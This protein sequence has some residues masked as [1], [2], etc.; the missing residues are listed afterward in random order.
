MDVESKIDLIKQVGEEILT[1]EELKTLLETKQNIVAY[2]GF[3]PSGT[4]MHI[5]QG[6]LRAINVNKMTEAG[7]KFKM[8]VADWHAW[9]NNKMEGDL[10][11]IQTVGEYMIEVWKAC[12][13]NL[14]KVEFVHASELVKEDDYWKKVLQISRNTTIK[15]IIRTGQIMG[16]IESEVQHSSQILYPCMQAADIFQ[17]EADVCQLGMDQRKV[18]ILARELGEKLGYWK[19]IVV[20]HH[21]L[22]G[23]GT[24][25]SDVSDATERAI[26]LKMSKSKPNTA[27]FMND[28]DET[29]K[30]KISEAYCPEKA[31]EENP[32]MEYCKHVIFQKKENM[33]IKRP[34]KFGGDLNLSSFE[35]LEKI[36]GKGE[37]HP[38]DLKNAVTTCLNELLSPIRDS[39]NKNDRVQKLVEEIKTFKI[40]R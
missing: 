3:E 12:D 10:K 39:L 4:D 17:L 33:E 31:V 36:Y 16:R 13:M 32:I 21:M 19:P 35:E 20:S 24:P 27:I 15:R 23:L 9:A 8:L 40:T 34:E 22:M 38:S 29:V 1:E 18:N 6:L 26:A 30:K 5:A 37:L 25:A 2:D 14:E 28:D 7:C 11:K